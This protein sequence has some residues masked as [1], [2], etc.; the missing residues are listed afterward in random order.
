[1]ENNMAIQESNPQI[2]IVNKIQ[3]ADQTYR[4]E[5]NQSTVVKYYDDTLN[6]EDVSEK[7][8]K[9][10]ERQVIDTPF[11]DNH[12][13]ILKQHFPQPLCTALIQEFENNPDGIKHSSVLSSFVSEVFND[14]MDEQIRSYFN[15]EYSIFWWAI[16]KVDKGEEL[17]DK[18]YSSKWHC[19]AGPT[20]HLKTLTY[21]NGYDEHGS[22]TLYL[23][24]ST[25]DML[26]K[27]GYIFNNIKNR[28][29]ELGPLC[30]HFNIDY[31]PIKQT[32]A[33]GDTVIFNPTLLAH[34][35]A[36]P[37]NN[38][39]RYVLTFCLLPSPI[40][41]KV[42]YKEYFTPKYVCRPFEEYVS[43]NI[44]LFSN[45][46]PEKDY[47][48]ISNTNFISNIKHLKHIFKSIFTNDT[49][50]SELY[51]HI[52]TIDKEVIKGVDIFELLKLIKTTILN[53]IEVDK[54]T[55]LRWL[56]ALNDI[57]GY[58][59]DFMDTVNRYNVK[60][61]PNPM[62]VFWPDPTNKARP[63]SKYNMLPYVNKYPIMNI[64]TP[65]GSAGSCF[66]FEMA[67]YFQTQN[68]NYVITER[69]D[70][71][72][73]GVFVDGYSPK[74]KIAKFCANFGILFNTPSFKQL[75]E[76]AFKVREF[77]KIVYITDSGY[78]FDPYREN[79]YFSSQDAYL[80]DYEKHI[81]AVKEALLKCEVFVVTLGLNECWELHDGT[82]MSRN[83]R[84]NINHLVKH[85]T[86]TVQENVDNIQ[87][88]FNIIKTHNPKFKLI[89]SVSPIPFLAT[90]RADEQHIISANCHSKAVLRVAA[91]QLVSENEDMYYLPSYELITECIKN[92]WEDDTRHVTPDAVEKVVNMF[93]EIFVTDT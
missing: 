86:L 17:I 77:D 51:Q 83:P 70:D 81:A 20:K 10:F 46:D 88:F 30:D 35:A 24:K 37:K 62:A 19:D 80:D 8:V 32:P 5:K 87:E 39:P 48:E 56:E 90:G 82:V 85:K 92:A 67:R 38:I 78:Y 57:S 45:N 55:P 54:L 31:H 43:T 4:L 71:P 53:Q 58:E 34:R 69:S 65:I 29:V 26:K 44:K 11:I 28:T 33:A 1:M 12:I 73:L 7:S 40:D 52:L 49:T 42:I 2:S 91:D 25:T 63:N 47:I 18:C 23:N 76:K 64:D 16:Y 93:K 27:V 13:H 68:Y 75:A 9:L 14:V 60:N 84:T 36:S 22:D 21:L 15:S 3:I 66:A 72:N 6:F 50:G 59:H 74:D 61:K 79:V 41:W 89:I